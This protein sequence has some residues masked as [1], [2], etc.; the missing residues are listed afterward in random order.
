MIQESMFGMKA[1]EKNR[2]I[3]V[4]SDLHLGGGV[5]PD[6]AWRFCRFLEH[7]RKD[8]PTVSDPCHASGESC[9]GGIPGTKTLLPPE[10]IILLGDIMELWD[11]RSQD[12]NRAFFDT[13]LPLLRMRDMDCDVVYVAGNHDEDIAELIESCDQDKK[14]LADQRKK[15]RELREK[16]H[17]GEAPL[18]GC[19]PSGLRVLRSVRKDNTERPESL[20][21][22]WGGSRTL[23]ICNRHYPAHRVAGG[24]EGLNVG[25][26]DYAFV[27]GQQY[28]KQQITYSISQAIGR[29]VDPVDFFQDLAS[30]SVAKKMKLWWHVLIVGLAAILLMLLVRPEF[31]QDVPKEIF[32]GGV[33]IF[34]AATGLALALMF[35]YGL[36]L[37][38]YAK[39]GSDRVASANIL[40]ILCVIGFI[41]FILLLVLGLMG[42]IEG[43]KTGV[44]ASGII[45]GFFLLLLLASIYIL[46]VITV[47]VL[48][49]WAKRGVYNK[50]NIRGMSAS[51]VLA[52]EFDPDTYKYSNTKVLIFGHT[53]EPDFV[54]PEKTGKIRLLLNTGTWEHKKM[55][56]ETKNYDTFAYI[57]T[58]GVCC[59]RWNDRERKIECFCKKMDGRDESLCEYIARNNIILRDTSVPTNQQA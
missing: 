54:K 26:I 22:A 50:L 6:T 56:K 30:I 3:I 49:A 20:K 25:G 41:A 14:E 45:G 53:H 15:N 8:Q 35:L 21:I 43:L 27:H 33:I 58:T 9:T 31:L 59:L 10:K 38:G 32:S 11:S 51:K 2:S 16:E 24:E 40:I 57:D 42:L 19:S 36:Y 37:F 18:A 29:R 46:V 34:G 52:E 12:R 28:D 4:V 13:M 48:I 5:D 23:E 7:L 44:V 47:P 39:R 1:P 55:D 17:P